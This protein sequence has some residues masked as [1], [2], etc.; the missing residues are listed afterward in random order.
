[1]QVADHGAA[2]EGGAQVIRHRRGSLAQAAA[3]CQLSSVRWVSRKWRRGGARSWRAVLGLGHSKSSA[4]QGPKDS[5][6]LRGSRPPASSETFLACW[7]AT[8][9]ANDTRRRGRTTQRGPK[10]TG[11]ELCGSGRADGAL[12]GADDVAIL[13]PGS[14]PTYPAGVPV[15][16]HGCV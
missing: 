2:V 13:E 12:A 11:F 10:Q 3:R 5:L 4:R 1:R 6:S 7:S 16:F 15:R 14:P 9:G 8:K